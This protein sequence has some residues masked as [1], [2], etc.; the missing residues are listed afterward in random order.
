MI[1]N[2][3]N[4]EA[5]FWD[6]SMIYWKN[7]GKSYKCF[8]CK[9]CDAYVWVHENNKD[10]PLGTMANWELREWRKKAHF[11]LDPIRKNKIHSR[12]SIYG[13][14][15]EYFWEETHIGE[16]NILVCKKIINFLKET[17]YYETTLWIYELRI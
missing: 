17:Y 14:L 13:Q 4:K 16:S 12:S 9:D 10:R 3:C 2:Y 11:I 5:I 15:A 7:Y 8:Y 6:N 1:C